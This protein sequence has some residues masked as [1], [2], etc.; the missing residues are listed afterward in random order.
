MELF[1]RR[2]FAFFAFLFHFISFLA[3]FLSGTQKIIFAFAALALAIAAI[4]DASAIEMVLEE[5]IPTETLES[6]GTD[7]Y[8]SD[9]KSENSSG[10]IVPAVSQRVT[11]RAPAFI[12]VFKSKGRKS[13]SALVASPAINSTS[14]ESAAQASTVFRTDSIRASGFLW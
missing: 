8:T 13:L 14:G 3:I 2:Y 1:H 10:S 5:D 6:I 12:A 11:V 4:A 7:S 9:I